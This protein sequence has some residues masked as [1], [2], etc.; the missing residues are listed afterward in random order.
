MSSI[1]IG[2]LGLPQN[3]R[4]REIIEEDYPKLSLARRMELIQKKAIERMGDKPVVDLSKPPESMGEISFQFESRFNSLL[5]ILKR[6]S[7]N[8]SPVVDFKT[9]NEVLNRY[10][11]LVSVYNSFVQPNLQQNEIFKREIFTRLDQLAGVAGKISSELASGR[12]II[13]DYFYKNPQID[14][15]VRSQVQPTAEEMEN[16]RRKIYERQIKKEEK[17]EE[18]QRA[19]KQDSVGLDSGIRQFGNYEQADQDEIEHI[20]EPLDQQQTDQ[21]G[22]VPIPA[23][24]AS[25]APPRAPPREPPRAPPKTSS[26]TS[27]GRPA[28]ASSKTSVGRPARAETTEDEAQQFFDLIQT[29]GRN[30]GQVDSSI[31][32]DGLE[33]SSGFGKPIKIKSFKRNV[34]YVKGVSFVPKDVVEKSNEYKKL[35]NQVV[36]QKIA[37]TDE[38]YRLSIANIFEQIRRDALTRI[39]RPIDFPID[40]QGPGMIRSYNLPGESVEPSSG[41]VPQVI[42]PENIGTKQQLLNKF[43]S[44]DRKLSQDIENTVRRFNLNRDELIQEL[45][46]DTLRN[47]GNPYRLASLSENDILDSINKFTLVNQKLKGFNTRLREERLRP[48]REEMR[49]PEEVERRRRFQKAWNTEPDENQLRQ[50]QEQLRQ[51]QDQIRQE[52]FRQQYQEQL[53][54][55]QEQLRQQYQEQLRQYYE[56]L[57]RQQEIDQQQ[58]YYF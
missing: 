20:P 42:G 2:T 25:R 45:G 17:E 29:L 35:Y 28:S 26:K 7:M 44:I 32:D 58:P 16:I 41:P 31:A 19:L 24:M 6:I 40:A 39:L 23:A 49:Q 14:A 1:I 54:R 57:Q 37:E 46:E 12:K 18:I 34:P 8:E 36:D 10:P 51:R 22:R 50:R 43:I 53:E 3:S 38:A 27:V 56:Q 30:T 15:Y 9:I 13:V 47:L 21:F 33:V 5:A 48:Y 55:Q 52:R 4:L 11:D